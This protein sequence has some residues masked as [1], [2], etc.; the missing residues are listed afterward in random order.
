MNLLLPSPDEARLQ[1]GPA[2]ELL[3]QSE[4]GD[5][6]AS[7]LGCRKDDSIGVRG[8]HL[9]RDVLTV[10]SSGLA[11]SSVSLL[12]Q[13]V[14]SWVRTCFSKKERKIHMLSCEWLQMTV[15]LTNSSP[16]CNF[17][18]VKFWISRNWEKHWSIEDKDLC[19]NFAGFG[20]AY[21]LT[22]WSL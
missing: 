2:D 10:S 1:S 22:S 14:C 5:F 7:L 12:L 18:Q 20:S 15:L 17:L 9:A 13:I 11:Q 16:C 21:Y 4:I 6:I 8:R 19:K 3:R